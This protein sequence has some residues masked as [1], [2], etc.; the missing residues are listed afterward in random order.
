MKLPSNNVLFSKVTY[1]RFSN[2]VLWCFFDA[3][4]EER[5]K[6]ALSFIVCLY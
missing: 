2:V 5:F 3:Q 6:T 4:N 1:D